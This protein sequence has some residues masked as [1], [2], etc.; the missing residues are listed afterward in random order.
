MK[1][2]S[3][4]TI[5]EVT[6]LNA[7]KTG[8]SRFL[9]IFFCLWLAA[10]GQGGTVDGKISDARA[11]N[12][13]PAI[14]VVKDEDSTLYL[15]GTVHLLPDDLN[16]Q[17]DDMKNALDSAGTVYFEIPSDDAAQVEANVLTTNLG[18]YGSGSRLSKYLDSYQLKLLEA[19]SHN[20]NLSY[21]A[22]D[23]MKPWLAAEFLT[24]AAAVDVG[25]SPDLSADAALKN[26][27]ERSQKN[28]L[29]LDTIEGQIRAS[30]DQPDFVQM[31]VLTETLSQFND[32]GNDMSRVVQAWSVGNTPF[33]EKELI[34]AF[35][36]RSPDYYQTLFADRNTA[37][38]KEFDR[39]MQ[40]SGTGFAAIGVG[41]LLGD[42]SVLRRLKD[43][44]YAVKRFF[45][46]QGENVI[47]P[48]DLGQ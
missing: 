37:W 40:G 44:G 24:V 12:D 35:K 11:R 19:A 13:G 9:L 23:S 20:G 41:H 1:T 22:L 14:W 10:C 29:Y 32:I 30:A 43:E 36:T 6:A 2:V 17:R 33:L 27:A 8:V 31:A 39:F 45:A 34:A 18:L 48:V 42:E 5:I 25:L 21:A 7:Q 46:F 3:V 38:A 4:K 15:F 28:I 16:W 47:K 26:R